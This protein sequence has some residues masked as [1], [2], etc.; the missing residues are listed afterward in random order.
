[1]CDSSLTPALYLIENRCEIECPVF[2]YADS[3]TSK[4][5]PC[6]TPCKKCTDSVTCVTCEDTYFL[7]Q[8]RSC[9]SNCPTLY[10]GINKIC[11]ACAAPCKTCVDATTKCLTC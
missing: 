2:Y 10:V 5:L 11:E 1:M 4:C 6:T 9:I 7:Y 8:G 3:G